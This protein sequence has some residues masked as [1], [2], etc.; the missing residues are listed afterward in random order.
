MATQPTTIAT[1][2][3]RLQRLE[4]QLLRPPPGPS[5]VLLAK[6][7]PDAPPDVQERHQCALAAAEADGAMV[8][9]LVP[10]EPLPDGLPGLQWRDQRWAAVGPGPTDAVIARPNF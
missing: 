9:L 7:A 6:P 2:F 4:A 1:V 3:T 5:P 8:I 10:L